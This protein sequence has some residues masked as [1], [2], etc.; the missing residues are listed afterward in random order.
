MDSQIYTLLA[1]SEQEKGERHIAI[2][3]HTEAV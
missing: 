3:F 1:K 2:K